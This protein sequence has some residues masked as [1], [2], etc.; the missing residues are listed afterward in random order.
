MNHSVLSREGMISILERRAGLGKLR[1]LEQLG[2]LFELVAKNS[3]PEDIKSDLSNRV[4]YGH[5]DKDCAED[6]CK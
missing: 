4:Y 3:P 5:C 1:P 2:L 6:V